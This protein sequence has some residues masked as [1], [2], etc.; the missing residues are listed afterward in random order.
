MAVS[1]FGGREAAKDRLL[2][3]RKSLGE[4]R[5]EPVREWPGHPPGKRAAAVCCPVSWWASGRCTA[6][7]Q[8]RGGDPK[9]PAAMR[10]AQRFK[11]GHPVQ[12]G[13]H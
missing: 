11:A 9:Q 7:R 10:T 13:S 12:E 4:R 6:L 3:A 8:Q 2:A 5:G 1:G